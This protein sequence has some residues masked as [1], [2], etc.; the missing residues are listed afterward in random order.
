MHTAH[1]TAHRTARYTKLH[2]SGSAKDLGE[3]MAH[4]GLTAD[5]LNLTPPEAICL[6]DFH[7]FRAKIIAISPRSLRS[8]L[9]ILTPETYFCGVR[10]G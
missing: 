5:F 1:Y 3:I 9:P 8:D 10:G 4:P 6:C 2:T 7:T